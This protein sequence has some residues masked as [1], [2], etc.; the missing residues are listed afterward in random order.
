MRQVLTASFRSMF[1]LHITELNP[2]EGKPAFKRALDITLRP[3]Q[4]EFPVAMQV[5]TYE[6][7]HGRATPGPT[8]TPH[9]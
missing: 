3:E 7:A 2:P 8:P 1:Q 5:R 9:R 4:Q 6:I